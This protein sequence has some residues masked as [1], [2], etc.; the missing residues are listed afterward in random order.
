MATD[1]VA[2]TLTLRPDDLP[3]AAA[4]RLLVSALIP[5]PV[6]WVSTIGADGARNLAPFSFFTAVASQPLTLMVSIG[7]RG[8]GPKDTL[9][10]I[11]E[12]GEFVVHL[13][14]VGLAARLNQTS[15]EYSYGVD[16][17]S[18]AGLTAAPSL[19]VRP[20]R[21]AEAPI[22]LEARATQIIPVRDATYTMVLG[23]VARFHVRSDL[24]RPD[25]TVDATR[26]RPLARLGG[27]EYATLAETFVLPR[28]SG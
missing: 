18:V 21:V 4:Y 19:D 5:R 22:A 26:L 8:G 24:L 25:M 23:Q 2:D 28:P 14:D 10:N 17:F 1:H 6:A 9:R 15:G 7:Q 13:A 12:T 3:G 11:Q 27:N 16:E 20:P